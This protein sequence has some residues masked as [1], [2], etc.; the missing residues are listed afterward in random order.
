MSN[1]PHQHPHRQRRASRKTRLVVAILLL[2]LLAL[3]IAIS[4]SGHL[5]PGMLRLKSRSAAAP[6]RRARATGGL[7]TSVGAWIVL[8]PTGAECHEP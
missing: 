6:C 4:A 5:P 1:K 7:S 2:A 3:G 8:A